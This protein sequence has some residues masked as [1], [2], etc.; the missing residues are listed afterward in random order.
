M[1]KGEKE[2]DT[3]TCG[4]SLRTYEIE[5]QGEIESQ[6]RHKV[7]HVHVLARG[8]RMLWWPTC[9]CRKLKGRLRCHGFKTD[10]MGT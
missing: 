10:H 5:R 6:V 4:Q 1:C 7:Q 2:V 3:S 9:M 8:A